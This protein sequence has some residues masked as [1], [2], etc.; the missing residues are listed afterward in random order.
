VSVSMGAIST[1]GASPD[2]LSPTAA[3]FISFRPLVKSPDI[4]YV[5]AISQSPSGCVLEVRCAVWGDRCP[6]RWLEAAAIEVRGTWREANLDGTSGGRTSAVRY[7]HRR[8]V[9]VGVPVGLSV[10]LDDGDLMLI[11]A[12]VGGRGR[13]PPGHQTTQ[14]FTPSI[15]SQ[16]GKRPSST[17]LH[18]IHRATATQTPPEPLPTRTR[19]RY[20]VL[21]YPPHRR[22]SCHSRPSYSHDIPIY[23]THMSDSPPPPRARNMRGRY[24]LVHLG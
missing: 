6:P 1:A 23:E 24:K 13:G 22:S 4:S 9:L 12:N 11:S 8:R 7:G 18:P 3:I 21:Y 15:P 19:T 5:P 2:V 10:S 14:L 17:S 20:A 16:H